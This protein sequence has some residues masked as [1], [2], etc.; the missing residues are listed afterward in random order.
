MHN[1][2]VIEIRSGRRGVDESA[3]DTFAKSVGLAARGGFRT[4]DEY[5]L[6]WDGDAVV[7]S[8]MYWIRREFLGEPWIR[9]YGHKGR[10]EINELHV[11]ASRQNGG[12][13]TALV[14]SSAEIAASE[15]LSYVWTWPRAC[16]VS[17][18]S[19]WWLSTDCGFC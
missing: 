12:I 17:R 4:R 2:L 8:L 6:A 14:V 9:T 3:I 18:L 5:L 1:A 7:G 15:G 10:I 13:G 19:A 11:A 16:P